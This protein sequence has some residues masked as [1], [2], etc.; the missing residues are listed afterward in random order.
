[1]VGETVPDRK[2]GSPWRSLVD[3]CSNRHVDLPEHKPTTMLNINHP[4]GAV[5]KLDHSSA[6]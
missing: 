2:Y 3:D 4:P 1:M 6:D 5:R